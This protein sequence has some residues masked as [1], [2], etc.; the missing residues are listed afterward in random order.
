M[1]WHILDP[2]GNS[3]EVTEAQLSG[4][5]RA[6]QITPDTLVWRDGLPEW[7]P[8]ASALPHLFAAAPPPPPPPPRSPAAPLPPARRVATSP[9]P[10][11]KGGCVKWSLISAGLLFATF[12]AISLFSPKTPR[13]PG[14]DALDEAESHLKASTTSGYGDSKPEREAAT[15]TA[16]IAQSLRSSGIAA[17]SGSYGRGKSGL[18]RRAAAG[19]DSDGFTSVCS[20]R[21]DTA[22]FLIHV[23]DL[24][25]FTDEAKVAMG[26]WS[27]AAARVGWSQL[28]EPR[29]AKL[30]VALKG[31]LIYD[32]LL[33]GSAKPLDIADDDAEVTDAILQAGLDSTIDKPSDITKALREIFTE[34]ASL[35]SKQDSKA[36]SKPDS[37]QDPKPDQ[38]PDPA[39]ASNP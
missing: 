7:I 1:N 34:P 20:V 9:P 33:T 31:A 28:P 27:W 19:M 22:V 30:A 17:S 14:A 5:A 3:M 10:A 18:F 12:V 39:P 35:S 29:P 24:R 32:R 13:G 26:Q 8:A 2:Q 6:G 4:I 25:K 36:D 38:K 11:K 23:P 16:E 21:G 15:V 37:K